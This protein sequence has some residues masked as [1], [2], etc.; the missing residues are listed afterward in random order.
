LSAA[1]QRRLT[2]AALLDQLEALAR[3]KPVLML[4]EDAHWADASSLEVLPSS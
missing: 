1:Q 4:F 3:Q 2:L